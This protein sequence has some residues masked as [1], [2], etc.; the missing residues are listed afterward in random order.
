MKS[1]NTYRY[2]YRRCGGKVTS[3]S[4]ERRSTHVY[5]TI[6]ESD[7]RHIYCGGRLDIYAGTCQRTGI[8]S[9]GYGYDSATITWRD[10]HEY[11]VIV[12]LK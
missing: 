4:I 10:P 7:I 3:R 2:R 8:C 6:I 5:S 9:A 11:Q 12:G 1:T